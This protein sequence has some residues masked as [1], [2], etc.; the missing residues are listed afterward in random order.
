MANLTVRSAHN[1]GEDHN[2]DEVFIDGRWIIVDPGWP[3]FNP[4]PDFYERNRSLNISFVYGTYPNGTIV[5][6][7]ERYT[8]VSLLK[9]SVVDEKNNPI[10]GAIVRFDSFNYFKNG[11]EIYNCTTD[12]EG[13]CKLKLGGGR[14]RVRV[15]V[16]NGV[17]GYYNEVIF[18]LTEGEE[19]EIRIVIKKNF[20]NLAISPEMAEKFV[21]MIE[22]MIGFLILWSGFNLSGMLE[23]GK[24]N[25][26]Q[27]NVLKNFKS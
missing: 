26:K 8:N 24:I 1:A 20:F 27:K 11:W 13:I 23:N 14:Y 17:V 4:S 21:E 18:D 6:L 7:T 19:K 12:K 22:M 2:W 25:G 5:D 16:G 3:I 15:F 9:V 10:E